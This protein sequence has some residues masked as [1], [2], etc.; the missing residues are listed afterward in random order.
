MAMPHGSGPLGWVMKRLHAP[1]YASRLRELV[2]RITPHLRPGD[3]V[4]D[5]GCG[6]G[7]LGE[8]L[9]ADPKA[10]PGLRVEGLERVRR[11]GERIAVTEYDGVTAPFPDRSFDVVIL[12][13]VLHHEEDPHRLLA[14]C[15]RISKRLVIVKDHRLAG[16]LARQRVSLIDWAANAPFGVVCLY[17]YNTLDQWRDWFGRHR[18]S[19]V[20]ELPSMHLYPPPY[21]LLF[22]RRL[23]Y[24]AVLTVEATTDPLDRVAD[25][26][27]RPDPAASPR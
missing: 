14:E 21:N 5:V 3:R 1:V 11:D 13:D 7:A 8:A 24:M 23:Q 16:P 26:T 10:P 27:A 19:I 12:A 6:F 22:G 17:R 4:L 2:R 20:D 25:R 9:L 18:L 15:A